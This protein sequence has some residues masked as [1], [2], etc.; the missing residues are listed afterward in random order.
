MI[1]SPVS[2]VSPFSP[3][4]DTVVSYLASINQK[5]IKGKIARKL[6]SKYSISY[7]KALDYADDISQNIMMLI[8]Q[9]FDSGLR[10]SDMV[11]LNAIR[12]FIKKLRKPMS[13]LPSTQNDSGDYTECE[14]EDYNASTFGQVLFNEAYNDADNIGKML[15]EGLNGKEIALALN[16]S[17][18]T[19]SRRIEEVKEKM[20]LKF[21]RSK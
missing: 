15:I 10:L 20:A 3:V 14:V 18:A 2:P 11:I 16:I 9:R 13:A 17:E 12:H 21:Y 19:A 4:S 5:A 7:A 1:I 8:F 6:S